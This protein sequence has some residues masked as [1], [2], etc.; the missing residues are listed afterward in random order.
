MF[1]LVLHED[2]LTWLKNNTEPWEDAIAKWKSTFEL[3]KT[4]KYDTVEEF[5]RNWPILNDTR[6]DVLVSI[7]EKLF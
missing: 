2:D 4:I 5:I 7:L 1:F 3:R 6:S